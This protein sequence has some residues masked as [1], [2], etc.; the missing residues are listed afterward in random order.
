MAFETLSTTVP[1][2]S[3]TP[4]PSPTGDPGSPSPMQRGANY[5]F[6][7]LIT[8]VALLLIFVGCGIGSRRRLSRRRALMLGDFD[9]WGDGQRRD[10]VPQVEPKYWEPTFVK[11]G[12]G[13]KWQD[14]VPLSTTVMRKE[15]VPNSAYST[16]SPSPIPP[17]R[18]FTFPSLPSWVPGVRPPA[19]PSYAAKVPEPEPPEAIQVT[20]MIAMPVI[21]HDQKNV[22]DQKTESPPQEYQIGVTHVPWEGRDVPQT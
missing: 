5:F 12:E 9:T 18:T 16:P 21:P 11:G 8:F 20:V 1:S 3:F 17:R 10:A 19:E 6:G 15:P 22:T 13:D 4:Q 2:S 7:F 14:I